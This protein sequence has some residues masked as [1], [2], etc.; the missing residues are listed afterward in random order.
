MLSGLE[1]NLVHQIRIDSAKEHLEQAYPGIRVVEVGRNTYP[2]DI[3][4]AKVE[5]LLEDYPDLDGIIVS[6][7]SAGYIVEMVQKLQKKDQ[8]SIIAFDFTRQMEKDL[9]LG[10]FDALIG[11]NLER[12]GYTTIY[13]IY[14]YV[15]QNEI[16]DDTLYVALQIKLKETVTPL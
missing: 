16:T 6:C 14:D 10:Y 1:K 3:A 11:V 5:K 13:A 12:L 9:R 8:L 7:G 2:E 4:M 15:F